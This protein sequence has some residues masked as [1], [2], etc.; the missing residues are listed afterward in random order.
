MRCLGASTAGSAVSVM[1]APLIYHSATRLSTAR[2]EAPSDRLELLERLA[3]VVAVAD[4]SAGRRPEEVLETRRCRAA[5][6]TAE[7]ALELDERQRLRGSR[8]GR[9]E[10]G[11]PKLFAALG[12]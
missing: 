9:R 12:G 4:R 2:N 11:H 3:A 6:G 10:A 5:V 7:A 1:R 8:G